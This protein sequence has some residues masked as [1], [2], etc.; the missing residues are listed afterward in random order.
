[1]TG[2]EL[3]VMIDIAALPG[4][5]DAA[6]KRKVAVIEVLGDALKAEYE[7]GIGNKKD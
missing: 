7:R 5:K 1:M 3:Y 2:E 4:D 6:A